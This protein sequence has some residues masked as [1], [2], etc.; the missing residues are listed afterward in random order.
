M[1]K[2][3]LGFAATATIASLAI[4]VVAIGTPGSGILSAPVVARAAF[5]DPLDIKFKV[6]PG[7][8]EVL[9]VPNAAETVMQQIVIAPGGTTG[10]HSHPGPVVVLIKS[11]TMSFFSSEDPTCTAVEYTAGEAF[12][13]SGQGHVHIAR[14]LGAQNLELWA[15]YFDVPAGGGFRIDAPD[16]GN[17]P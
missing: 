8:Q 2:K 5:T 12:V 15:T 4:A 6:G 9:H 11:G 1:I 3:Q 14:N 10:W 16:P 17:C 13:D 7:S